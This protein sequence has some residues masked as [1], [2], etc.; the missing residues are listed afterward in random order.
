MGV[1]RV[2]DICRNGRLRPFV[3]QRRT[4]VCRRHT[5]VGDIL[6][7]GGV[8]KDQYAKGRLS[9]RPWVETPTRPNFFI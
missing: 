1:G 8:L 9:L 3:G 4:N 2:K 6:Y 5:R 7:A